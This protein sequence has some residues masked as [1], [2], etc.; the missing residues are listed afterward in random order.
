MSRN[1]FMRG[2]ICCLV[3]A[4]WC[5]GADWNQWRGPDTNG[6]VKDSPPLIDSI[7]K[8]G[9]KRVW[10]TEE[11]I[12]GDDSGGFGSVTVVDGKSYVYANARHWDPIAERILESK[13]L[14]GVLG[15]NKDVPA[16]LLQKVEAA[17]TSEERAKLKGQDLR[18]WMKAWVDN[19]VPKGQRA[20]GRVCYRRLSHGDRALAWD[21]LKKLADIQ[22]RT[23]ASQKELDAWFAENGIDDASRK[24]IMRQIPTRKPVCADQ[25][26]CVGPDGKVLWKTEFPTTPSGTHLSSAT[27]CVANGRCYVLG[28]DA[29]F[30][31]LDAGTGD[32]I[33]QA[34]VKTRSGN[35]AGASA[36]VVN[37]VVVVLAGELMGLDANTGKVLWSLRSV[38]GVNG[39]P[40][41]WRTEGKT[42]VLCND[43][44]RFVYCVDPE[45]GKELWK[46]DGGGNATPVVDGNVMVVFAMR[47]KP[48]LVAYRL[49]IDKPV[50]LWAIDWKDRGSSPVV[51]DGYVYAIGGQRNAFV[52]CV[53]LETGEVAWEQKMPETEIASPVLADGKLWVQVSFKT[54][55][56]YAIRATPEKYDLLGTYA[57]GMVKC[58]TPTIVDGRMYLR[59]KDGIACYDIRR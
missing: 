46:A 28:S 4:A 41:T 33:W 20:I 15:W 54:K 38:R 30:Y 52:R 48:G 18:K 27:P 5:G 23:F 6:V 55:T 2:L 49:A 10:K 19:H 56:L 17:R 9:L 7:P 25:F 37:D 50:K 14:T 53:K 35:T 29:V 45:T 21:V 12:P 57:P 22:D 1:A 40:A 13:K 8:E 51:S 39:S 16:D 31:C 34:K 42:Y 24:I 44:G 43:R 58:V 36:I 47:S 11:T 59:L 32:A 3:A 26:Y